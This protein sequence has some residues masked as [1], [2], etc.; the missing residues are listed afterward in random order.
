MCVCVKPYNIMHEHL[1][2][3]DQNLQYN[4][5]IGGDN[6]KTFFPA[7][8]LKEYV[9]VSVTLTALAMCSISDGFTVSPSSLLLPSS[10]P[11]ALRFTIYETESNIH[12]SSHSLLSFRSFIF[13]SNTFHNHLSHLKSANTEVI[14]EFLNFALKFSV[15]QPSCLFIICHHYIGNHFLKNLWLIYQNPYFH[16]YIKQAKLKK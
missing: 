1:T 4:L 16:P 5:G 14:I 3:I 12:P 9:L 15:H 11:S 7:S 13:T 8:P 2:F 10:S 6:F